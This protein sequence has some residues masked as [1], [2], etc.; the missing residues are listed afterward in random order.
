MPP[1]LGVPLSLPRYNNNKPCDHLSS[2]LLRENTLWIQSPA[3]VSLISPPRQMHSSQGRDVW[4]TS[5]PPCPTG[6]RQAE[7]LQRVC[8]PR[9]QGE[10]A[11]SRADSSSSSWSYMWTYLFPKKNGIMGKQDRPLL[12]QSLVLTTNVLF[13]HGPSPSL[14]SSCKCP[15]EKIN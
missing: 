1:C 4:W 11:N 15:S 14:P 6:G 10:P 8:R 12:Q 3:T 9:T 5:L 2:E 7:G 13:S